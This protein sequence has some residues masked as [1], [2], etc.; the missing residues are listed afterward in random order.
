MQNL[1]IAGAG[2]GIGLSVARILSAG[3]NVQVITRSKSDNLQNIKAEIHYADMT[4]DNWSDSVLLPD[5]LH[6]VV[7]CP[8]SITLK[9]FNRLSESDFLADFNQNV[10]GAVRL[11]QKCLPNLKRSGNASVV[12]FSTVAVKTGMPFHSSISVSKGGVESLV[13]SLAAEYA[14]GNIRFNAIAPS[15]TET[16]LASSLINT[17]EKK[18]AAAKRHPLQRIGNPDE[19]ASLT[20][21][22]LSDNASWIT[23]QVIGIDGGIGNLK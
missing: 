3:N 2:R 12:L 23:G 16:P 1:I 5:V 19:I 8:G 20:A 11:L 17:P 15:L 22:L 7:Y 6:G 13:R 21:F 18:D 4:S 14:A 10:L 9:P